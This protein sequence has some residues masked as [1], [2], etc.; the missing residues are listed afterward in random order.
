MG[1]VW[2]AE[3][4]LLATPAA[5]K[6]ILPGALTSSTDPKSRSDLQERFRREAQATSELRSPHTVRLFDFGFDRNGRY[7]YVM[8]LLDGLDMDYLV[9]R[10]G[11]VPPERCIY[12]LRQACLSLAEAHGRGMVHRDIKPANLLV[13]RLGVQHDFVKVLDFGLVAFAGAFKPGPDTDIDSSKITALGTVAGTPAYL[14]P[15]AISLQ[16]TDHRADLYALG[17][18]AIWLLTGDLVFDG[19][20]Q[21]VLHAH[22]TEEPVPPSKRTDLPIPG[23]LE[24]LILDCLKKDPDDRPQSAEALL[25]RLDACECANDWNR[26]RAKTWWGRHRP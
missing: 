11:P 17:A 3:H 18:V 6:L 8:E 25:R 1:E 12:L 14:S 9:Q 5:V 19:T 16:Q 15:E 24:A 10:F 20:P 13:S 7:F 23:D 2:K 22:V 26:E 21:E 4:R